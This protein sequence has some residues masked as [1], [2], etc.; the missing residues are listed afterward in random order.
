MFTWCSSHMHVFIK[1]LLTDGFM[2]PDKGAGHRALLGLQTGQGDPTKRK[3]LE[4]SVL[5]GRSCK[6]SWE[7]QEEGHL[8]HPGGA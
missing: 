7:S 5:K 2:G 3:G 1:L 6:G 8:A 4:T